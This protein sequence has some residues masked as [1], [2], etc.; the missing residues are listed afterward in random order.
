MK[1]HEQFIKSWT[2][3]HRG[4]KA[5]YFVIKKLNG[6]LDSEM[7]CTVISPLLRY[8]ARLRSHCDPLINYRHINLSRN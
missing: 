2:T 1:V 5:G 3:F 6:V 8:M 4:N 7:N